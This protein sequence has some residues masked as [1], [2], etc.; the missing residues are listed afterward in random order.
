MGY[1]MLIGGALV[2][3]T[4]A[5]DVLN[6][7]TGLAFEA[8]PRADERQLES[9]VAAARAAFPAWSALGVDE[10]QDKLE[11]IASTM[12]ARGDDLARVLTLE[13]GK[14]LAE[15]RGEVAAEIGATAAASLAELAQNAAI[16]TMLPT[17]KVVRSVFLEAEGGALIKGLRPGAVVIDMSSSDPVGTRELGEEIARTGAALIDAPVSGGVMRATSGELAIMVGADSKAAIEQV[18]PLLLSMGQRV[19]ETGRLGSGHAMKALNNYAGAASF[20]ATSEALLIGKRFGLDP[21]TIIDVLDASTGKN[22]H[23]QFVMKDHVVSERFA[24][25]FTVGLLAKDVKIAADLGRAVGLDAPLSRLVS[26]RLEEARDE[27]GPGSDNT[28]AIR[29]WNKD[30]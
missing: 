4:G 18:R 15:A 24:T 29:A 30:L 25:G 28:E 6:P 13:Q 3:G 17:G 12:E 20:A 1:E 22:F 5:M 9:A 19:F 26:Q 11:A 8:A 16:I 14:P 27:L 23:T 10:R 21:N 2:K 7:A